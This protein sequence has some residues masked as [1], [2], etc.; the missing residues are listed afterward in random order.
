MGVSIHKKKTT[1]NW[2]VWICHKGQRTSRK[3]GKDRKTALKAANQ[4]RK[5]LA[6]G[7]VDF[8]NGREQ[9]RAI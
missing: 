5:K 2:Y 8:S 7:Q 3:I 1:G 6:L 9:A 4:Y